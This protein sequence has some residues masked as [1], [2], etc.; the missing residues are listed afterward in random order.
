MITEIERQELQAAIRKL[1]D[2]HI[3]LELSKLLPNMVLNFSLQFPLGMK[4]A[5][6]DRFNEF[7]DNWV[8]AILLRIRETEEKVSRKVA[9]DEWNR[10]VHGVKPE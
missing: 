1:Q 8:E 9:G 10:R 6:Q 5:A 2:E 7:F 4:Y 3:K